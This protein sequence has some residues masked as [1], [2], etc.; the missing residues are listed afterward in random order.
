M[1]LS[2]YVKQTPK[3]YSLLTRNA[4][5]WENGILYIYFR[6]YLTKI[7]F[8]KLKLP[9]TEFCVFM[10]QVDTQNSVNSIRKALLT[11]LRIISQVYFS[12][13]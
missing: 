8:K 2:A 5:Q 4:K 12:D 1:S 3:I 11:I 6:K 10:A 7:F 9:F 13:V